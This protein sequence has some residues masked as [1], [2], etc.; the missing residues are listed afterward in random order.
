[1][2]NK[3]TF[4]IK[5]DDQLCRYL[6][7]TSDTSN[8]CCSGNFFQFLKSIGITKL[9]YNITIEELIKQK[10][11]VPNLYTT[12]EIKTKNFTNTTDINT[13]LVLYLLN[14]K[15]KSTF[16]HP[17]DKKQLLHEVVSFN[18]FEIS[19]NL[20]DIKNKDNCEIYLPYWSGY[21]LLEVIE[22]LYNIEKFLNKEDGIP[23][24]LTSLNDNNNYWNIHYKESFNRVSLYKTFV[25]IYKQC[26]T[27]KTKS[28]SLQELANELSTFS[29]TTID[30]LEKDMELLLILYKKWLHKNKTTL[31]DNALMELKKDIYYLLI[32]LIGLKGDEKY[33]FNKWYEATEPTP[34]INLEDVID[35]EIFELEREFINTAP[36]Y[37][38]NND[39][40]ILNKKNLDVEIFFNRLYDIDGFDIWLRAFYKAHKTYQNKEP[41]KFNQLNIIDYILVFSIR[42]EL[43]VRNIFNMEKDD[44][45]NIISI[46]LETKENMKNKFHAEYDNTKLSHKPPNLYEKINKMLST[47]LNKEEIFFLK[48]ILK[49]IISRNYFAHHSYL[50][51]DFNNNIN[52]I[53][54]KTLKSCLYTIYYLEKIN[55]SKTPSIQMCRFKNIV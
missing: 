53:S 3:L 16:F 52:S 24:F 29:N 21:I 20:N 43:L 37:L 55:S 11:F 50:D 27:T 2:D 8:Q 4:K 41:I 32:W 36:K 18:H 39:I 40:S 54:E 33:Y 28:L 34:W 48:E 35:F 17:F 9:P 23:R 26:A 10:I 6:N 31:F 25:N 30:I 7:I 44:L 46:A 42:T 49:F 19:E 12:S 22:N 14:K 38:E 13:Q 5:Y 45:K 1:M 15:E 51:E 47:K